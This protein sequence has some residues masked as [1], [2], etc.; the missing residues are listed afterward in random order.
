ML[1]NYQDEVKAKGGEIL[2]ECKDE[3]CGGDARRATDGGGGQQSLMKHKS[4]TLTSAT[5]PAP[6]KDA[7]TTSATSQLAY[8][9]T[10]VTPIWP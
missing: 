9:A 2:F 4:L 6:S 7:S 1:R 8:P 10:A 3:A 5:A